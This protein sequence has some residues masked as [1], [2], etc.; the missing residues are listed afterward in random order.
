MTSNTN[1]PKLIIISNPVSVTKEFEIIHNLFNEGLECLHIRK[2]DYTETELK[3]FLSKI[4]KEV[5]NK[6]VIHSHYS[7]AEKFHLKGIHF[8]NSFIKQTPENEISLIIQKSLSNKHSVSSSIH[9]INE[10]KNLNFNYD[11]VFLSPVFDSISKYGYKRKFNYSELSESLKKKEREIKIIALGG[12]DEDN[13]STALQ[14]GFDGVALLGAI[15]NT[16]TNNIINKFRKIQKLIYY[17]NE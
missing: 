17:K 10:I 7:L 13:T 6:I 1:I 16:E 11:Y 8:T 12:V 14:M 3:D 15:W 2:P 4:N 9:Q 5:L